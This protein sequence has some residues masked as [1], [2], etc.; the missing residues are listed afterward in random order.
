MPPK[1]KTKVDPPQVSS[2]EGNSDHSKKKSADK[3]KRERKKSVKATTVHATENEKTPKILQNKTSTEFHNQNFNNVSKT[4]NGKNWNLKIAS[5][6]VD[7]LRA[8]IKVFTNLLIL[9]TVNVFS[10]NV[11]LQ[12]GGLEYLQHEDPDILCL[13]EIKC[14]KSKLP[15]EVEVPG[16]HIFWNPS[17]ADGYAGLGLYTK[18]KPKSIK[19]GIGMPD[20][21]KEGRLMIAEYE[22]F[23]LVNV[24]K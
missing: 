22:K 4:V 19:Y 2:D 6:N 12:K 17:E 23:Y 8:W 10:I 9:Y 16:F 24:C 15:P 11:F 5:W 18:V 3:P 20:F 7:G 14:S 1:K 21:D 13:Q